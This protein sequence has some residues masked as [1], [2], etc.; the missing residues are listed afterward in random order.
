M[1]GRV[2]VTGLTL[3]LGADADGELMWTL[4]R[5]S[6]A[7]GRDYLM[8]SARPMPEFESTPSSDLD[9]LR[10]TSLSTRRRSAR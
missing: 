4:S 3:E 9:L 5:V 1:M 2:A 6:T 10:V 7:D 8:L